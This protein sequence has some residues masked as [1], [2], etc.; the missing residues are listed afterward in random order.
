MKLRDLIEEL[1]RYDPDLDVRVQIDDPD[2]LSCTQSC[3]FRTA[4]RVTA[5]EGASR[6][7]LS[8]EFE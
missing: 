5:N 6:V 8:L 4:R 7:M 2:G 3:E 1:Q